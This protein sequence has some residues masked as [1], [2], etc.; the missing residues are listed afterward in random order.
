M[1][2]LSAR[3][4]EAVRTRARAYVASSAAMVVVAW[5]GTAAAQGC[6]SSSYIPG[7]S[8][9]VLQNASGAT[10][11]LQRDSRNY[12]PTAHV[13]VNGEYQGEFDIPFT[14]ADGAIQ[15]LLNSRTRLETWM[16]S[17]RQA[18]KAVPYVLVCG[19]W[20]GNLG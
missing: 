11:G 15:V 6:R 2:P 4:K 17:V 12:R 16:G 18:Y 8:P 5:A 7:L 9:L 1:A 14:L 13:W 10:I 20:Y 3:W 19:D